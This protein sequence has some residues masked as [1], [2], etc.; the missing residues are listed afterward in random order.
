MA[1]AREHNLL[2]VHWQVSGASPE[3]GQFGMRFDGPAVDQAGVDAAATAVSTMWALSTVAISPLYQLTFVR[4]ARIG[5]D[6]HYVPGTVSIDHVYPTPVNGGGTVGTPL[7]P[8]QSAFVCSLRTAVPR[9]I[10]HAGRFYM[11]PLQAGLDG[12]FNWPIASINSRLNGVSAMLST[13]SGGPLGVLS[14][15][16]KGNA[17]VNP[18]PVRVVDHIRADTRPDV[19][20]RRAKSNA[21]V[22]SADFVVS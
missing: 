21:I 20:R 1:F 8:L 6:G 13:L 17:T 18:G 14:V 9:G 4:G 5:T 15:F 19:Q 16:S 11:P 10:G 7:M 2:T 12:S 22:L 3:V